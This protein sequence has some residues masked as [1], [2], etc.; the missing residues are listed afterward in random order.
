MV[1]MPTLLQSRCLEAPELVGE[2]E[3][4]NPPTKRAIRRVE[5]LGRFLQVRAR[6]A[7]R[8]DDATLCLHGIRP[9]RQTHIRFFERHH[10]LRFVFMTAASF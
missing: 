5:Q 4:K 9:D 2:L 6:L 3:T 7:V 10:I 8:H 1:M